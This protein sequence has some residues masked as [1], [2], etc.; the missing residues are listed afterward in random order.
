MDNA[1]S[2]LQTLDEHLDHPVRL[3]LYGR[4]ALHLGFANPPAD[5]GKSQDVD[6]IIPLTDLEALTADMGFWDAQEA[7]NEK[8]RPAGLYITHLFRDDQVFLRRGWEQHILPIAR[9]TVRWLKLFRPATLDL[10]LTKM[11]RGNDP[12]DMAAAEFMI[13]RDGITEGQLLEAFS[14]MKPIEMIELRDAFERARPAV[15][16]TARTIS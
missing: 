5:A 7:T 8:L 14:Q 10:I 9:P 2:I 13:R 3:V 1:A 15:L 12:Q 4:A 6:C 16:K 11:M